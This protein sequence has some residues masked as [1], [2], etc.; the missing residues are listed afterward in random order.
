MLKYDILQF[1]ISHPE[2]TSNGLE[3]DLKNP[4]YKS[5]RINIFES[6][7]EI[8]KCM[9]WL[10]KIYVPLSRKK[11]ETNSYALKYYVENYFGDYFPNGAFVATVMIKDLDYK[12]VNNNPS[13]LLDSI[14][15]HLSIIE[16][17]IIIIA[18][19]L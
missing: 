3:W 11:D 8:E 10:D 1:L 9:E 14:L 12:K 19:G 13:V 2:L 6:L 7:D 17:Y 18:I 16:F 4:N 5:G 15:T